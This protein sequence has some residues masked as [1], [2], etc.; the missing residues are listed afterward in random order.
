MRKV[1]YFSRGIENSTDMNRNSVLIEI[2]YSNHFIDV[3]SLEN[4]DVKIRDLPFALSSWQLRLQSEDRDKAD[5]GS[6]AETT[7]L[8]SSEF[9]F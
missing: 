6:P 3:Y 2:V 8:F 9:S 4:D 7:I 1:K 5:A